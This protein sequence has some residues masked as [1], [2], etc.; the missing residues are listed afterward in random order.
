MYKKVFILFYIQLIGAVE[1]VE[2]DKRT[3][4]LCVAAGNEFVAIM[5]SLGHHRP[6]SH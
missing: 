4:V 1:V 6:T 5:M 3:I 2:G